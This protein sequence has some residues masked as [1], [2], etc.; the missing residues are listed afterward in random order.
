MRDY[1]SLAGFC[2]QVTILHSFLCYAHVLHTS[3]IGQ[4]SQLP[5]YTCFCPVAWFGHEGIEGKPRITG[6]VKTADCQRGERLLSIV[7][8]GAL[9]VCVCV[10]GGWGGGGGGEGGKHH[11]LNGSSTTSV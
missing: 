2:N 6:Y 9:Y 5:F 4:L 11:T 3:S 1:Y 7:L 10:C 8:S